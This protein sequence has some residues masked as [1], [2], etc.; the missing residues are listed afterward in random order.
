M[1]RLL[2]PLVVAGCFTPKTPAQRP[3]AYAYNA[4]CIAAG[5]AS[6]VAGY[7]IAREAPSV[8]DHDDSGLG[9]IFVGFAGGAGILGGT[10]LTFG[11]LSG[12]AMTSLDLTPT[13]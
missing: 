7:Y 2:L 11:G 3:R 8:G 13:H 10:L 5:I 1:T 6:A 4:L 9:G 12:L